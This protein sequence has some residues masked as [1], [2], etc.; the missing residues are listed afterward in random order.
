MHR[1]AMAL[2]GTSSLSQVDT[3]S[4]V[5]RLR[6]SVRYS[7]RPP[8]APDSHPRAL[9]TS[10]VSRHPARPT[11]Q[12]RQSPDTHP[13]LRLW[14]EGH[15]RRRQQQAFDF[16]F[17]VNRF[18]PKT[19]LSWLARLDH[20]HCNSADPLTDGLEVCCVFYRPGPGGAM[21]VVWWWLGWCL[22]VFAEPLRRPARACGRRSA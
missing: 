22:L 4:L 12:Q 16:F 17:C 5:S 20:S 15:V 7:T 3:L 21:C 1:F 6:L 18:Y 14:Q 19:Q 13:R 8:R 11:R 10:L 2:L 9:T